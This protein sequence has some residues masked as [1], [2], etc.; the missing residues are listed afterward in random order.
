MKSKDQ[1]E[2]WDT[3]KNSLSHAP[4]V[5]KKNPG[6]SLENKKNKGQSQNLFNNPIF[7]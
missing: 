7:F 4:C 1:E 3:T 5:H 6:T 2:K